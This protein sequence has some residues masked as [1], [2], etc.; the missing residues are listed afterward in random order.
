MVME[1]VA[2][3]AQKEEAAAIQAAKKKDW[4]KDREHLK[5]L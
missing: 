1:A 3:K 2:L 4:K 5:N